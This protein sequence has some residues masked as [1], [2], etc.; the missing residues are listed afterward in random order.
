MT[1]L[2]FLIALSIAAAG[3]FA[4]AKP[5]PFFPKLLR[6]DHR[7]EPRSTAF[8]GLLAAGVTPSIASAIVEAAR[9][10]KNLSR[11]AAGTRVTVFRT[12]YPLSE[13]LRLAF[14]ISE[15]EALVLEREPSPGAKW[16]ARLNTLPVETIR[17]TFTGV[18]RSTLWDS[19]DASGLD[20]DLIVELAEIFAWEVDFNRDV[21][22]GD[23]WRIVVAEREVE[24]KR[25]GWEPISAAE[26]VNAG[27]THTAVRFEAGPGHG[28][29]FAPDGESLRR[30]FLKS[31]LRFGRITSGFSHRRFHPILKI[32]RPHLGVDYGAP[33]GTPVMS[34][35]DG[36]VAKASYDPASGRHIVVRHGSGYAT[37]YRHLSRFAEGIRPGRKVRQGEVIG[38]VGSTGLATGPHLHF[39]F[40][41]NG[42]V[43]NPIGRK[44]P[45]ADPVPA[46]RHAE[47]E[48]A[49]RAALAG[50]PEWA[51]EART[52]G[53]E[54]A[55]WDPFRTEASPSVSSRAPEASAWPE[56]PS[57][58]LL[59]PWL[60]PSI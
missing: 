27:E 16:S 39:E 8:D 26:Y 4:R 32:R 58:S 22:P 21:R 7:I 24:G 29:Y 47:F 28:E 12:P 38:Y 44:F 42:R 33:T 5:H 34:V 45:S 48:T 23:R 40:H 51:D 31:P 57:S 2:P 55:P 59:P 15:T 17:R 37:A 36:T 52:A 53:E 56:P 14:R 46:A 9:P 60:A 43:L 35:G 19:A 6:S 49:A 10:I 50:L 11:V 3:P 30:K 41:E 18:V 54:P 20:S 25:A 13:V 1:G